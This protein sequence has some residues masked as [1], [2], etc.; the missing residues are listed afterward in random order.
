MPGSTNYYSGKKTGWNK[1][2][3][4]KGWVTSRRNGTFGSKLQKNASSEM[5]WKRGTCQQKTDAG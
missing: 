4:K 2:E 3:L 1:W 5:L